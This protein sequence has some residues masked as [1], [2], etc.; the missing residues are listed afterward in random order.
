MFLSDPAQARTSNQMAFTADSLSVYEQ[1]AE[2]Q[3]L[4]ALPPSAYGYLEK[5]KSPRIEQVDLQAYDNGLP[6]FGDDNYMAELR[7]L[8][9]QD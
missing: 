6:R 5:E 1:D 7:A 2:G 9:G 3:I 8:P 4:N